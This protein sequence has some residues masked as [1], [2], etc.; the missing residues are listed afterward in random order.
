MGEDEIPAPADAT[1]NDDESRMYAHVPRA[2]FLDTLA[3]CRNGLRVEIRLGF[4]VEGSGF[5]CTGG[6]SEKRL[7]FLF[8][9]VARPS[10]V[11]FNSF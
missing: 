6:L 2:P 1:V 3:D 9:A 11:K 7:S 8:S 4:G 10:N 5:R